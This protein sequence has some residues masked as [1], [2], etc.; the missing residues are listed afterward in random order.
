MDRSTFSRPTSSSEA[1]SRIRWNTTYFRVNYLLV[2]L[3]TTSLVMAL[4]PWSLVVLAGLASLWF[5]LIIIRTAPIT[6]NGREISDREKVLALSGLSLVV[7][8]LLTSVGTTL[9]YALGLSATL[10]AV[11][12]A[13]KVPDDLFLDAPPESAP[14]GLL[15]VFT[16][17]ARAATAVSAAQAPPVATAV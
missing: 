14:G 11:H 12:A 2:G 1:V 8:F 13:F 6:Y 10:I 16:G 3:T 5:Y 17:A 9:I 4:H 15:A 7:I